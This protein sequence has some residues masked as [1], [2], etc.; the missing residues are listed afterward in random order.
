M[1]QNV[2]EAT[3]VATR[4]RTMCVRDGEIGPT[5]DLINTKYA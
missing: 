1:W 2:S 3:K 4:D 5:S